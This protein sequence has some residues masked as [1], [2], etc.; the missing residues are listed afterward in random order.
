[1]EGRIRPPPPRD[2]AA[3]AQLAEAF[4]GLGPAERGFAEGGGRRLIEALAGHS[5][6][7]A[8]LAL[9]EAPSLMRMAERGPDAAFEAALAPLA[10]LDPETPRAALA[11]ALRRAKRQGALIAAAA[12]L[13]GAWALDAVTGALSSLAEAALDAACSVLLREAAAR[14]ALK[15][16]NRGARDPRRLARGS[17][18][19]V[20]GMGKLGARELNYSSDIDLILLYDPAAAVEEA[21]AGAVFVR[22]ARD[23]VRLMEERTAE[24]YV[25]RTDLRL[26]PDP[27]ATPLAVSLPA[28]IAYYESMGQNWERAAMIKARPVA[29]DRSLG[30]QFLRDIRPFVWRRHLDFAMLSDL[31]AIRRRIT[32]EKAARGAHPEVRVAGHDVKLGRGGIREVEFSA[33]MLQLIWGGREPGLRDP[34]TLGAL[35]ALAGAGRIPRRAAAELADAY[36]FLREVEH[37]LQMV[38]DRQTQRLPEDEEGLANIASFCGFDSRAAFEAAM[39]ATLTRVAGHYDLLFETTPAAAELPGPARPGGLVFTGPD[40][41]PAT[42]ATLAGM[43]FAEPARVA[44]LVRG[45]LAG[46]P[47]ATRSERARAILDAMLPGLLAAFGRQ[48]EPDQAL[49][50]F[51][52]LLG[53]LGAGVHL[54]S[55]LARN[56]AL[57][58]RIAALLGAA[59]AL[60]DHLARHPAA[61]EGLIGGGETPAAVQLPALV[62]DSRHLEEALETARRL[63]TERKFEIDAAALEGA[64]DVDAAA[65]ARSALADAA[66]GALLPR[67]AA[68]FAQRH[69]SLAGAAMGVLALGK[70]GGREMLPGSDLDLILLY[71]HAEGASESD[72]ARP[73]PASQYFARLSQLVVAALSAPGA[74]GRLYDVDMRLRPSGNKGPVAVSLGAFRRYHAESSWTWERMALTRARFVAGPPALKRRADAALKAALT[75]ARGDPIAD[76]AAMR[77]RM[78]RELPPEG[79]WDLKLAPGGLVDVE[80]IAQ[81]L[82]LVVAPRRP[83]VLRGRTALCLSALAEA[84]ALTRAEAEALIGADRFWRTLIGLIRLTVGRW[85]EAAL[86]PAVAETLCHAGGVEVDL[87]RLRAQIAEVAHSVRTIAERRLGLSYGSGESG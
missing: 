33:Q 11:V 67:I 57:V 47:R 54:L 76:A 39:T 41:D 45:W 56:T 25:F 61:L 1:M 59:P 85:R 17:G 73:L 62:K 38:A 64:L 87:A 20:L 5:P 13:A 4:A 84:R 68:E 29:G 6:Y 66:I 32:E 8:D 74:E 58:A 52:E 49:G 48:R 9:R 50:R 70:L 35:A 31:T 34:A 15:L 55:L 24:G 77:Q 44:A 40:D 28:A 2:T 82:Q 7:L 22:F 26:R 51:D 30:E 83:A 16:P 72:G 46:R 42:L 18:L 12:D 71:D 27:A 21:E 10:R 78:L 19:I 79:P 14:G 53:R 43:G 86:P 80:F 3:A 60:A 69:G 63:V 75:A 65:E 23:L 37:R 81:A 36:G